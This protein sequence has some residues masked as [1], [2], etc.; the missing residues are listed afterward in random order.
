MR[1]CVSR[2]GSSR[3]LFLL[4]ASSVCHL[5]SCQE[6]EGEGNRKLRFCES[7]SWPHLALPRP[8]GGS[9][10]AASLALPP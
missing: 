6:W 5:G 7:E 10:P 8:T 3:H 1:F 9:L 4:P 2:Y